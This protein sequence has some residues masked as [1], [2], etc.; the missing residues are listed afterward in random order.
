MIF[1]YNK[2]AR[3]SPGEGPQVSG[4]DGQDSYTSRA[5]SLEGPGDTI[6]ICI[7]MLSNEAQDKPNRTKNVS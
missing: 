4:A 6:S 7:G 5:R 3:T 1:P 2:K